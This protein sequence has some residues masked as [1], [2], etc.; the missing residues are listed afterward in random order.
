[1]SKKNSKDLSATAKK[2]L[3]S[4]EAKQNISDHRIAVR[5]KDNRL[6]VIIT[7]AVFIFAGLSQYVYFSFGP[8]V[9][10]ASCVKFTPTPAPTVDGKPA[11]QAP[12][13]T[14]AGCRDWNGSM[15]INNA[16]LGIKITGK[17]A[18][19]A[20]S[21]FIDL[22]NLG[23][24]NGISCHR[25]TTSGIFVLQCGDPKGDGTG[26]PGYSFGPLE[27]TP[28]AAEG[29]APTYKKGLLAMARQSNSPTSMGSQFFIIYK[30]SQ[31]PNDGAGGYTVF[32]E[33][34]S[35]ITGLDKIV[36]AGVR[37]GATDGQ[38]KIKTLINS[39]TLK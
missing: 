33:I 21:N 4:F 24:Y 30:D 36:A 13:P 17:E 32:G 3:K 14:V 26:G 15:T 6:A 2:T 34:T 5:A 27:N 25:L 10:P 18:P 16:K 8:G 28:A 37:G 22:V 38:P 39:I 29:V 35:G 7:A 9:D 11:L 19:Q 20:A 23:F 31:I 1:M 12:L